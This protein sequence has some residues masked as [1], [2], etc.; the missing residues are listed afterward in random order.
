V[1]KSAKEIASKVVDRNQHNRQYPVGKAQ[2]EVL[3]ALGISKCNGHSHAQQIFDELGITVSS[4]REGRKSV[5]V[6]SKIG[7]GGG[8]NI[9]GDGEGWDAPSTGIDLSAI[10]KWME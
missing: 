7:A 9:G 1:A 6:V 4:K 8:W 3:N 2:Q 10:E 5:P